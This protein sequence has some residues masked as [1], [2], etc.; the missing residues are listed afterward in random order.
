MIITLYSTKSS[1]KTSIAI[2]AAVYFSMLVF[3]LVSPSI[4][5]ADYE[6]SPSQMANR[7]LHEIQERE[8]RNRAKFDDLERRANERQIIDELRQQKRQNE[9]DRM[10][11]ENR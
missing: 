8:D 3:A 4:L 2:S 7:Y 6:Q 10:I 1:T 5:A 9:I 11:D